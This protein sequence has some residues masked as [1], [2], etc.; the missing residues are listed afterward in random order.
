MAHLNHPRKMFFRIPAI[1]KIFPEFN[2]RGAYGNMNVK[3]T[4]QVNVIYEPGWAES[5]VSYEQVE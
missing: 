4:S 5:E 2:Y 3:P 1:L